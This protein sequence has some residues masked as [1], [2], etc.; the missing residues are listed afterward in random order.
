MRTPFV[1]LSALVVTF[2][3]GSTTDALAASDPEVPTVASAAAVRPGPWLVR[4]ET[5]LVDMRDNWLNVP[6]LETGLT[7]GRDLTS[8]ASVELTA[9]MRDPGSPNASWSAQAVARG[10]LLA[11]R[12]GHHAL[13]LAGGAFVE[14]D[15]PIHGTVPFA[16]AEVAYVYRSSF[17]LTALAGLGPDLA[18]ATSRYVAPPPPAPA[19]RAATA[20]PPASTSAPTRASSTRARRSATCVSPSAGSSDVGDG[21]RTRDARPVIQI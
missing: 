11:N 3:F 4:V 14:I 7:F 15:H 21:E 16:H 17:G 13:T 6:G 2:L 18:L 5:D 10:V 8:R 9:S 20:S 1:L 19:R 12:T